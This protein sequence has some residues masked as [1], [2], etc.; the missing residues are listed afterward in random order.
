MRNLQ[1]LLERLSETLNRDQ[2]LKKLILQIIKERTSLELP[3]SSVE[4]RGPVIEIT[5]SAVVKSEIG[6]KESLIIEDIKQRHS[7]DLRVI[8]K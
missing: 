8:Y 4:L 7:L 6:L 3:E 5:S 2:E 1:S